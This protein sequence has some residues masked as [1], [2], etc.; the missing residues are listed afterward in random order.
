MKIERL[1]L[2]N[3]WIFRVTDKNIIY[4][5]EGKTLREAMDQAFSLLDGR[6][7]NTQRKLYLT[8]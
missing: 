3:K 8:K 4:Q 6:V 2:E 1:Q 5:G 7:L